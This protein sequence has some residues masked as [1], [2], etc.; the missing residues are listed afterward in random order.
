MIQTLM[1][2]YGVAKV[3]GS[4]KLK[5][6]DFKVDEGLGFEPE[7][8]GEHLFLQV[9]KTGLSTH[10]LIDKIAIDFELKARDIGYSGLKDKHAITRQ[11]ISLRLP[12]KSGYIDCSDSEDYRVI[13]QG[14]HNRKLKPGTHR[15]NHFDVTLRNLSAFPS[16]TQNQLELIATRGMANYFGQQRFGQQQDNVD[17]AMSA[18]S[19]ARKARRLSRTK[20]SLYLSALRSHL[21]N[22]ILSHRIE[23]GYWDKPIEGDVF[24]LSGS[25]SIFHEPLNQSLL[26]RF[27]QQDISSTAS[28][29]GSGNQMLQGR[30]LA[31]EDE[32]LTKF[33]SIR[34]CLLQQDSHLAMR[35]TRVVVENLKFDYS[36]TEQTLTIKATLPRGSYFT[37]LLNHFV[38]ID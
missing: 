17:R 3:T 35:S 24:M 13:K 38:D 27:E 7:G 1:Y 25:Q 11:W 18:F 36:D 21:F 6:T 23:C 4:I 16:E 37:T 9:E 28:L 5:N 22:Q 8:T 33:K 2:P 19:N 29:Y 34:D 20:R 26:D 31:V 32:V 30:A 12:G 10:E 15:K 14:W